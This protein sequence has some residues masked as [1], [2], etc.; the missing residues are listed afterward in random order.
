L[1]FL[2][3]NSNPENA[4]A[5]INNGNEFI[6]SY[7]RDVLCESEK[8]KPVKSPDK[9]I[10]CFEKIAARHGDLKDIDAISVTAGPG[11]FTGIR[12]GLA[13]AKGTAASLGKKIIPINN[14]ELTLNRIND[15]QT[16]L[17]YC[18]LIPAKAPE[19]YYSLYR[20]CVQLEYGHVLKSDLSAKFDKN[21]LIV[22][23]FSDDSEEKDNYFRNLSTDELKP[24]LESMVSLV[25]KKFN[26]GQLFEP[27]DVEPVYIKDFVIRSPKI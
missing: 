15:I 14:F 2:L 1:K 25:H 23:N 6:V 9:L 26:A 18:V 21:T 12:V 22:G 7:A 17:S 16:E 8:L 13:I 27:E 10:Q 4:F 5:A 11:S 3:I 19:Y 20:N 24:E